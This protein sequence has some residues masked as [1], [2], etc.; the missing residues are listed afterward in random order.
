MH[1]TATDNISI[2]FGVDSWSSF[3]F[4]SSDK[5]REGQTDGTDHPITT[6]RLP[7]ASVTR[8]ISDCPRV[9]Y[10]FFCSNV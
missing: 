6:P 5:P 9:N 2:D 7:P 1:M 8:P 4:Q 3:P 10:E